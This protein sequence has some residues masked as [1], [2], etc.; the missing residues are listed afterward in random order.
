VALQG[1]EIQKCAGREDSDTA[2]CGSKSGLHYLRI[3]EYILLTHI[4]RM[5]VQYRQNVCLN[6]SYT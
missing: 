2:L 6:F 3:D 4:K 1:E 5:W